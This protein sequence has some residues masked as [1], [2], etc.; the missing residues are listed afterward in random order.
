[1]IWCVKLVKKGQTVNKLDTSPSEV[2][3]GRIARRQNLIHQALISFGPWSLVRELDTLSLCVWF[4]ILVS[5][6]CQ[7]PKYNMIPLFRD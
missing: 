2:Q 1:M 5:F 7:Q 6:L 4:K 3:C